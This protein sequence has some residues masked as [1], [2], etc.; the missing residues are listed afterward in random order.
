MGTWIKK[1]KFGFG[2][3]VYLVVA[4]VAVF[5]FAAYTGN[6]AVTVGGRATYDIYDEDNM[7]SNDAYGLVTQQSA[8]AY[9]DG[10]SG[11]T[12][13][14]ITSYTQLSA[15]T[16]SGTSY[17]Q[18]QDGYAY[19]VDMGLINTSVAAAGGGSTFSGLTVFLIPGAVAHTGVA[20][21]KVD[22]STTDVGVR[23]YPMGGESGATMS[24]FENFSRF[25]TGTTSVSVASTL[26]IEIDAQGEGAMW[27][28]TY[29]QSKVSCF[30]TSHSLT[31]S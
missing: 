10:I 31:S 30:Q 8:R 23:G 9:M 2:L 21:Y 22:S 24:A 16:G 15:H 6:K 20:V 29:D 7:S 28:S 25:N 13:Y 14:P 18:L 4:L 17:I 27:S 11:L 5:S 1:R 19:Y 3:F 26:Y 12:P